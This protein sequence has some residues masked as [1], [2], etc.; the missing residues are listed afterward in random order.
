MIPIKSSAEIQAM[1]KSASILADVFAMLAKE[2]KVGV[3]AAYLDDCV[4]DF[5]R[6]RGAE[7]S[8]LGYQGYEYSTCISKNEEIVHGLPT[9]DKQLFPGDICSI[10]AGVYLNGFHADAARTFVMAP[11]DEEIEHLVKVTEASFFEGIK[12]LRAGQ[13]LGDFSASVQ[14]YVESRGL[15]VVRDLYSHGVGRELHED[16]LIPHYGRAGQGLK[17]KA[18]MVFAI[19]PMVNIGTH[20]ILTLDDKWTIITA[21]RQWSCHYENTVLITDGEPEILTLK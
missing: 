16:P 10:D 18:G 8:F 20:E 12:H 2:V 9:A 13:R 15:T 7:P 21:D 17:L 4:R 11:V 1:K 3:S 19:E 14:D 5:I 6:S